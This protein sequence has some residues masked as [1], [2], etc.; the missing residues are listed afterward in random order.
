MLS[1]T[2]QKGIFLTL[3]TDYEGLGGYS[4]MVERFMTLL[5]VL[6]SQGP[7]P[8]SRPERGDSRVS[9]FNRGFKAFL[10]PFLTGSCCFAPFC[11]FLD[12]Q[13]PRV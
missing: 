9:W 13:D 8:P 2:S 5:T 11:P 12:L 4:P 10:L 1:E 6:T 7:E 3:L